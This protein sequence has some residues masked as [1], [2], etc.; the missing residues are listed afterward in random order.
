MKKNM[1]IL[2]GAIGAVA[3]IWEI[4]Q[5]RKKM[6]L[7]RQ[8]DD[9]LNRYYDLLLNWIDALYGKRSLSDYL[10]SNGYQK[11]AIYG[12]G[13]MGFLLYEDLKKSDMTVAYFIDKNAQEIPLD[14]EGI[15][16]IGVEK[17]KE[18]EEV[19]AIIVTP[20][21]AFDAIKN[22]L[23]K[24]DINIPIISLDTVVLEA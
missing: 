2:I 12:N 14:I 13:T 9:R 10:K 3:G 18:Q 15:H 7:F 17:I 1:K 20:I 16:T 22:D 24:K 23:K 5:I 19:D 4:R 8:N 6:T 21:H 11:V